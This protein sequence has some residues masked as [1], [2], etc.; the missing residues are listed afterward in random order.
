[1]DDINLKEWRWLCVAFLGGALVCFSLGYIIIGVIAVAIS[2]F[3]MGAW[4]ERRRVDFPHPA[5]AAITFAVEKIEDH[6]ERLDFLNDW[7]H[8]DTSEWPEF[9][10]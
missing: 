7:L 4:D 5:V 3:A 10:Q 1:M 9:R 8:G 6:Y 2:G